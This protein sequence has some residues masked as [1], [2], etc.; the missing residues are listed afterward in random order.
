MDNVAQDMINIGQS[1]ATAPSRYFVPMT[2]TT[3]QMNV[4]PGVSG[5][6]LAT[7]LTGDLGDMAA[8]K[9]E[10]KHVALFKNPQGVY[11]AYSGTWDIISGMR[12]VPSSKADLKK[13]APNQ[14]AKR[15]EAVSSDSEPEEKPRKKLKAAVKQ[16]V[17]E[18]SGNWATQC[19]IG[20]KCYVCNNYGHM[21]KERPDQEA[22]GRN[23]GYSKQ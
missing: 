11:N 15:G 23:D 19:P 8:T 16:G 18:D 14:K 3:G 6:G 20:H 21:V 5:T 1:W 17:A 10:R 9:A 2:G 4:I 7:A 13:P 12:M 22:K